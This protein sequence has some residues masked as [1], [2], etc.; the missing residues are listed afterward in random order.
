MAEL[1]KKKNELQQER[2]TP[3][4]PETKPKKVDDALSQKTKNLHLISPTS[5]PSRAFSSIEGISTVSVL[6]RRMHK[7][8]R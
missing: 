1:R 2:K 4:V 8:T 5:E 7:G 6:I 3:V